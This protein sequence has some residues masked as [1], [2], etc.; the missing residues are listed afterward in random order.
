MSVYFESNGDETTVMEK[1]D[2]ENENPVEL[3]K[4]GW[5]MILD[6]FKTYSEQ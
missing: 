2:P 5:Q 4:T 1:F 6:N 3:Q